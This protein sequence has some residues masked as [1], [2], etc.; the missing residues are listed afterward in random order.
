M[1]LVIINHLERGDHSVGSNIYWGGK[2]GY[3]YARRHWF[4]TFGPHFGRLRDVGNI[5]DR[6][7]QE[8][9]IS[10]PLECPRG[11]R[12]W[13][14]PLAG[15]NATWDG[16]QVPGQERLSKAGLEK[17]SWRGP[18]GSTG[19]YQESGEALEVPAEEG[20]LQYR[21]SPDDSQWRQHADAGRSRNRC[22]ALGDLA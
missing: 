5:Y 13:T 14:H 4:Q 2:D 9:Y 17:A 8:E 19:F 6:Q 1:D 3:S 18:Q 21:S 15:G 12:P 16:G 10:A 11:K 20:W 7:L 22:H